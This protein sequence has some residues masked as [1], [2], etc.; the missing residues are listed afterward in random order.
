[1]NTD[2]RER[3]EPTDREVEGG[4][5]RL[6][7]SGLMVSANDPEA[8]RIRG[9]IEFDA[10]PVRRYPNWQLTVLAIAAGGMIVALACLIWGVS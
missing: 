2:W 3:Y 6:L 8:P 4:V 10:S 1:M 7:R 5:Y 9:I